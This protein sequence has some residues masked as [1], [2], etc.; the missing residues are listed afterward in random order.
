MK[1]KDII[2]EKELNNIENKNKGNYD[3]K[4]INKIT[5]NNMDE[6]KTYDIN[7]KEENDSSNNILFGTKR[8]RCHRVIKNDK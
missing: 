1:Y 7:Y 4:I 6:R 5:N 2:I 8:K 3:R